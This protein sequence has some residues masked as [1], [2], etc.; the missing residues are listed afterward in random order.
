MEGP[1]IKTSAVPQASATDE[2]D[3]GQRQGEPRL[4]LANTDHGVREPRCV[5]SHPIAVLRRLLCFNSCGKRRGWEAG[6]AFVGGLGAEMLQESSVHWC[7]SRLRVVAPNH[8]QFFAI[9]GWTYGCDTH[10]VECPVS[11]VVLKWEHHRPIASRLLADAIVERLTD[12][13][14]ACKN[15]N[16]VQYPIEFPRCSNYFRRCAPRTIGKF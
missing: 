3:L 10:L 12:T 7:F 13:A 4:P 6:A 9:F 15:L 14:L 11:D 8:E 16:L 1:E 2:Q 5:R